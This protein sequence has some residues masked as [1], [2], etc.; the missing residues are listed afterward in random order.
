MFNKI[1]I[2]PLSLYEFKLPEELYTRLVKDCEAVDWDN[3][4]NRDNVQY[5][6]KTSDDD[7]HNEPRYGYLKSYCEECLEEVRNDLGFNLIPRL[8]VSQMWP[9]RSV[10]DQ[11][12][13]GHQHGWSFFTGLIYVTGKTGRTWFS[14]RSEWMRIS[15]FDLRR[16]PDGVNESGHDVI[17]QKDP[18]P[19]TLI[20]FPSTLFHSVDAVTDDEARITVSFN[21]F[22]T[23]D[24]GELSNYSG[25]KLNVL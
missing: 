4:E 14:R 13:H 20:I 19:G 8:A 23:G 5:F 3:V 6:G 21:S 12:H 17:Y 11:W 24:V 16:E 25:V 7:M 22:P 9:N 10:K 18:V 2:L 15:N 1:D